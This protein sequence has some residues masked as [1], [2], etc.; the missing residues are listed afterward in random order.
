M[1]QIMLMIL[2]LMMTVILMAMVSRTMTNVDDDDD[3]QSFPLLWE[4]TSVQLELAP[5]HSNQLDGPNVQG[6]Y[7]YQEHFHFSL[8]PCIIKC[9]HCRRHNG[10]KGFVF[11]PNLLLLC[12][13]TSW[14]KSNFKILT[15]LYIQNL[16][17]NL[18][19]SFLKH[20]PN[21]TI[22]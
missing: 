22:N 3:F 9:K 4:S 21:K 14:S 8:S 11:S 7:N 6:C 20:C 16:D 10:H 17:Q 19:F 1:C 13:I 12:H 5:M 18:G 2:L 15:S